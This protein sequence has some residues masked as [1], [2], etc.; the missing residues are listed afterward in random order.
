[1]VI[2]LHRPFSIL[3]VS[4]N[5]SQFISVTRAILKGGWANSTTMKPPV[6][7]RS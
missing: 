2:Y 7:M 6:I 1:M 3:I 5:D 4:K